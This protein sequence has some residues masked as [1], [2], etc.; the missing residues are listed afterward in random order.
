MKKLRS[1][2]G[3]FFVLAIFV[4][5]FSFIYYFLIEKIQ[6]V[7]LVFYISKSVLFYLPVLS[8]LSIL[9]P[10]VFRDISEGSYRGKSSSLNYKVTVFIFLVICSAFLYQEAAVPAIYN[11]ISFSKIM[12]SKGITPQK[13]VKFSEGDKFSMTE[14]NNLG[15][16]R[17]RSNIA[18]SAGTSYIYFGKMYD[19]NGPYFIEG[20]RFINYKPSNEPDYIITSEYAKIIDDLIYVVS[21][22]YFEY[23]GQAVKNVKRIEGVKTIVLPYRPAG[24]FALSSENIPETVSLID[25]LFYNDYS[26]NAGINFRSLGNIIFNR[27]G[28]YIILVL[29]L[30]ISSTFGS[31][32]KNMRMLK[33]EYLKTAAFYLISFFF[34]SLC[35]DTLAEAFAMIYSLLI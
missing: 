10:L 8:S 34:V 28:Y 22:Y 35:Y 11:S 2:I 3:L 18:F 13:A 31:A 12:K 26:F 16:L 27:I 17:M 5:I 32:F 33:G 29:M 20:F 4:I 9:W 7:W 6:S 1:F 24:I 14:F 30:I 15:A 21:P 19:G 23:S 25:V